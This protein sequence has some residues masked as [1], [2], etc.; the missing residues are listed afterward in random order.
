MIRFLS[1][2]FLA[3]LAQAALGQDWPERSVR[4]V[5][6]FA[7]SGAADIVAREI[8]PHLSAALGKPFIVENQPGAGGAVGSRV[9]AQSPADGYTLLM[10]TDATLV[11]GPLMVKAASYE[12]LASFATVSLVSAMPLMI[13]V[14]RSSPAGDFGA[15]VKMIKD[16]PGRLRYATTPGTSAVLAGEMF[17]AEGMEIRELRTSGWP[18]AVTAL[19]RGEVEIVFGAARFFENARNDAR[20]R[21]LVVLG[22]NR[23]APMLEL[24][25]VVDLNFP[26]LRMHVWNGIVAPAGTPPAVV[27]RLNEAL[28]KVLSSQDLQRA[29]SGLGLTTEYSSPE[30]F[31][32][33]VRAEIERWTP[34][35]S[36]VA[37]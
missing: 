5:V 28:R 20:I 35:L 26:E 21:P 17:K 18:G 27:A 22:R 16:A 14:A 10:A 31:S 9:A 30:Q 29:F 1:L 7:P 8:A 36:K 15:L 4:L 34:V 25:S 37:K 2:L 33:F 6:P 23:Y 12:P 3:A 13:G 19:E 32:G 24:P 11:T